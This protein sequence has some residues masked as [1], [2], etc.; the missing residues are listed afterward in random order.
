ML[1][2]GWGVGG[3]CLPWFLLMSREVPLTHPQT[4]GPGTPTTGTKPGQGSVMAGGTHSAFTSLLVT[5]HGEWAFTQSIHWKTGQTHKTGPYTSGETG[6]L[7]QTATFSSVSS[8][9]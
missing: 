7:G 5:T 4:L 9:S 3:T 1:G 6:E 8:A 2:G